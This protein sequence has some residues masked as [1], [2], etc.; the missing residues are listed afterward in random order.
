MHSMVSKAI[1][2]MATGLM[3]LAPAFAVPVQSTITPQGSNLYTFSYTV[4]NE[5]G[6]A[7]Q[8]LSIY[9]DH[10][11]YANL[12]LISS[13]ANWD[14]IVIQPDVFLYSDG[15]VDIL[16]LG[17]G[18]NPGGMLTGLSILA[19]YSGPGMPGAQN[20]EFVDPDTFAVLSSGQTVAEIEPPPTDVDAPGTMLLAGLGM[21][22]LTLSRRRR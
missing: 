1:T 7:L 20:F 12:Q 3:A 19:R 21:M 10:Q 18:L 14:P 15:F 6:Q 13:P 22:A 5:T 4:N 2:F 8:E 17:T 16:A 11:Y 9:F